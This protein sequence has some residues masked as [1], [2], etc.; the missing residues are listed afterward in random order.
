M[1]PAAALVN[2]NSYSLVLADVQMAHR[3]EIIAG[4]MNKSLNKNQDSENNL[5]TLNI[6]MYKCLFN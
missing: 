2:P 6:Y 1:E 3:P 4:K 5:G